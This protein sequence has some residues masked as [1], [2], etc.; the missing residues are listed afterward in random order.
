ML[1]VSLFENKSALE[2][3]SESEI[4]SLWFYCEN[5]FSGEIP[6]RKS[7]FDKIKNKVSFKNFEKA[8]EG[9]PDKSQHK[10]ILIKCRKI[11]PILLDSLW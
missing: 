11:L 10:Q 3:G 6:L 1:E 9:K 2:S 7:S 5:I 4:E 8:I